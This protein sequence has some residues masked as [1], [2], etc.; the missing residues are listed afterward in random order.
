MTYAPFPPALLR[1]I[2]RETKRRAV[3][4]GEFARSPLNGVQSA[5]WYS[6]EARSMGLD[7]WAVIEGVDLRADWAAG[8][9]DIWL[10]SGR[11]LTAP[12][13]AVVFVRGIHYALAIGGGQ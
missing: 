6:R 3:T 4:A 2:E 9:C 1:E 10:A 7:P 5:Y 13:G 8:H 11:C 12:T